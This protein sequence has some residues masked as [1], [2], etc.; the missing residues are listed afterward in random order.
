MFVTEIKEVQLSLTDMIR[1]Q[2]MLLEVCNRSLKSSEL[3]EHKL[4]LIENSNKNILQDIQNAQKYMNRS[5]IHFGEIDRQFNGTLQQF[6]KLSTNLL[7]N[8]S[9]NNDRLQTEI[10]LLGTSLI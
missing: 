10:S 7:T 4:E 9:Q 8:M 5:M 3:A 1:N 6:D 2:E